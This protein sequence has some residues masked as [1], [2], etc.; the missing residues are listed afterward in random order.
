[1]IPV[2]ISLLPDFFPIKLKEKTGNVKAARSLA[3]CLFHSHTHD[4]VYILYII[5]IYRLS[6]AAVLM[7]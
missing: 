5:S 2:L 6:F 4:V 3:A 1:M 7:W